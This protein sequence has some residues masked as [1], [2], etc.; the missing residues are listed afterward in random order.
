MSDQYEKTKKTHPS[1]GT[2]LFSRRHKGGGKVRLFGSPLSDHATTVTLT[3][4]EAEIGHDLSRDRIHG[5]DSIIEVELSAAQFAELL[6]TMNVGC[7]VPCT[8]CQRQGVGRIKDP[9]HDEIEIDRVQDS[10]VG[11]IEEIRKRVKEKSKQMKELLKKRA[12]SKADKDEIQWIVDKIMQDVESN[13]PYVVDQFN[14]ATER[15]VVAAKSEIDAFVT[16]AAQVTGLKQL[17]EM[18]KNSLLMLPEPEKGE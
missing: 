10:F 11:R 13:W 8:I 1:Y 18:S 17:Q 5:G 4:Y 12:L 9:P 7:G 6:T 15:I 14:K 2:V 3:I 16:T